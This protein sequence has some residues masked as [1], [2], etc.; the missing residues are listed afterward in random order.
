MSGQSLRVAFFPDAYHEVDGVANTSRHFEAFARR[1]GIPFLLVHAGPENR[2]CHLRFGH[3][4]TASPQ[5]AALSA[6]RSA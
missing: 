2:G 4:S 6:R 1:R 3:P 5:S